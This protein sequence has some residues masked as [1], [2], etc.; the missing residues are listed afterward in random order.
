MSRPTL[1][2]AARLNEKRE[3][4]NRSKRSCSDVCQDVTDDK[5]SLRC[6]ALYTIYTIIRRNLWALSSVPAAHIRQGGTPCKQGLSP[7][8]NL[9][10]SSKPQRPA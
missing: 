4:K 2:N 7:H 3:K 8:F 9:H 6:I 5:N 10:C 1:T